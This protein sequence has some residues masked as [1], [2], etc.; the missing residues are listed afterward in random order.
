MIVIKIVFLDFGG[1]ALHSTY[2]RVGV[3]IW[4]QVNLI[5]FDQ[6]SFVFLILSS[7]STLQFFLYIR[8]CLFKNY[9]K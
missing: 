6:L 1:H 9:E 7:R 5:T 8:D 4:C 2:T 3:K